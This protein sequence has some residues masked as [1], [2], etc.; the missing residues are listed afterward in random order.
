[1]RGTR[2]QGWAGGP[3]RAGEIVNQGYTAS[4]LQ[5]RLGFVPHLSGE[6]NA[7]LSGILLGM[8]R[9]EVNRKMREIIK[10]SGLHDAIDQP[11]G[12]YSSGM[13]ARLGFSVAFQINPDVLLVDEV[14]GVGDADFRTKSRKVMREKI[15]SKKTVVLVS[16][17]TNTICQLCS[18]AVWIEDGKVRMQGPSED[19]VGAYEEFWKMSS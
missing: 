14:L 17:N 3:G 1:M 7:R 16:H 13:K 6:E 15:L 9:R 19:V 18:R 4:L 8:T 11:V 12:S 2:G 5:L 10:F